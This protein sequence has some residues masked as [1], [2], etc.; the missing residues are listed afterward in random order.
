MDPE[1]AAFFK[2]IVQSVI[3]V[4]FWIAIT[5]TAA[6]KGDNAFI[7]D[8]ITVGNI[9]FYVWIIISAIL[10]IWIFKKIWYAKPK[11]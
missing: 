1:M 11:P 7:Q 3:V 2:R 10:L 5:A 4:F 6:I 8:H 9:L